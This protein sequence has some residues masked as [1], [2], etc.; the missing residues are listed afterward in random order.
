MNQWLVGW[1]NVLYEWQT[2]Q[3]INQLTKLPTNQPFNLPT[4]LPA[5]QPSNQPTN[6][7]TNWSTNLQT[8]HP[9]IQL[10]N[11]TINQSINQSINSIQLINQSINQSINQINHQKTQ[12][13]QMSL[14]SIIDFFIFYQVSLS[15]I[16][17]RIIIKLTIPLKNT[18]KMLI[19][20]QR[21]MPSQ[22][23]SSTC[24]VKKCVLSLKY[25][26]EISFC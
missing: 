22:K 18:I 7:P 3:P 23:Y 2:S 25:M 5:D 11:Q 17:S 19:L 16:F 20:G 14:P 21:K 9:T 1:I 13:S 24:L 12:N 10:T 8:N 15:E 4:S 6:L 26:V